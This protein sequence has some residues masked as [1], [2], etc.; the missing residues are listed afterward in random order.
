MLESYESK[1][2]G[3][4]SRRAHPSG[5]RY[6]STVSAFFSFLENGENNGL[7]AKKLAPEMASK[8]PGTVINQRFRAGPFWPLKCAGRSVGGGAGGGSE[9]GVH[10]GGGGEVA[11]AE[12]VGVCVQGERRI[13]VAET[14]GDGRHVE[15]VGDQD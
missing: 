6:F 3:F 4:E 8:K 11:G 15:I 9:D 1:G 5:N 10:G 12:G 13:A 2:R 7:N 14:G